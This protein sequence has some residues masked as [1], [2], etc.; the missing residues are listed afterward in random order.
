MPTQDNEDVKKQPETGVDEH[1]SEHLLPLFNASYDNYMDKLDDL[2]ERKAEIQDKISRYECKIAKLEEK[3]ARLEATN[4]MLSELI[5]SGKLPKIAQKIIK[6]NE[7]KIKSIDEKQIPKLESGIKR[8]KKKISKLDDRIAITQLKAEKLKCFSNVLKSFMTPNP[9]KR[10]EMFRKS[11]DGLRKSTK[12]LL[13]IDMNAERN[14]LAKLSEQYEKSGS[15][16][17]KFKLGQKIGTIKANISTLESKIHKLENA[18]KLHEASDHSVDKT[19]AKAEAQVENIDFMSVGEIFDFDKPIETVVLDSAEYLHNAEV[20]ME[21]DLNMI[22]G[23]INNGK[24]EERPDVPLF[25]EEIDFSSCDDAT[26]QTFRDSAKANMQCAKEISQAL[27][28]NY[29]YERYTLN[30]EQALADVREKF[31]DDRIAFVLAST[32]NGTSDGRIAKEVKDFAKNT[33]QN[34]PELYTKRN[35]SISSHAGLINLFAKTLMK[36][37]AEREVE[38]PAPQQE[39]TKPEPKKAEKRVGL[40]SF[41]QF[42]ET[43]FRVVD[44]TANEILKLAANSEKPFVALMDVGRPVSEPEFAE[45]MQ[46]TQAKFSVDINLDSDKVHV[47]A[48]NEG[49]GGI[50][51]GDR[52]DKNTKSQTV[53]LATFVKSEPTHEQKQEPKTKKARSEVRKINPDYYKKIPKEDRAI[54]N[55]PAKVG[56]IIMSELEKQKVPFS[57]VETA[58][59]VTIT[60]S[61]ENESAFRAAED[62]A[63]DTHVRLIN[64]KVFKQIPKEDRSIKIMPEKEANETIQ[65]LEKDGISYSA[66]LDG[67]KSAVTVRKSEAPAYFSRKQMKKLAQE[68]KGEKSQQTQSKSK[69][70]EL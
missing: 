6:A 63:K 16:S 62:K 9:Q 65:K 28:Q 5:D 44:E 60:V 30:S 43:R 39:Q 2:Q 54:T 24:K 1:K 4:A 15:M 42:G 25:L 55:E 59:G 61:K 36:S 50:A 47:F 37:Q 52:T 27:S 57:A 29:N 68:V 53:N 7:D 3:V 33:L 69:G 14:N 18:P 10:R 23:I 49:K 40:L 21:D 58:K 46:S 8:N 12:S 13:N 17:E 64:P 35:M 34:V 32:L 19:I 51:E 45:I 41:E 70:Q 26:L 38:K 31:S 56:A 22:D 20:S 67:D 66:R 48:I 11:M